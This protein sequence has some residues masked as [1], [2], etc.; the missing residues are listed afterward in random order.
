MWSG[1]S[2]GIPAA[3]ALQ[4]VVLYADGFLRGIL[5]TIDG[6]FNHPPKLTIADNGIAPAVMEHAFVMPS[7]PM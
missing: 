6:L 4:A 2:I 1:W 3:E 5:V 7:R